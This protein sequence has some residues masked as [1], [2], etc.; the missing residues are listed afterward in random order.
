MQQQYENLMKAYRD[1]CEYAGA[2]KYI[3]NETM[4]DLVENR[5]ANPVIDLMIKRLLF[6]LETHEGAKKV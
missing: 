4:C 1:E 6:R 5:L 3:I 2:L